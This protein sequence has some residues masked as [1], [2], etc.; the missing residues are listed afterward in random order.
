MPAYV[1][2]L[3]AINLGQHRKFPMADLRT[4]LQ[5][6]GYDD[7]ATHIHTGNVFL[8]TPARSRDKLSAALEQLF[9]DTVGFEVPTIVTTPTALK[10]TYAAVRALEVTAPRH[11]VT[12][13]KREPSAEA[14]S[15]IDSWDVPG[16]GA[17]VLG[18][19]VYWWLD[20]LNAEAKISNATFDKHAGPATTRDLK[21]VAALVDKWC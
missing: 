19:S 4:C 9:A 10:E 1:A 12:F 11:Y 16:E 20:H 3:R 2:F 14:T 18:R 5:E 6:A 7:V 21:V 8:R 15:A 17:R 13:L